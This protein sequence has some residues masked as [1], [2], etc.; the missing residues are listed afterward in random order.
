MSSSTFTYTSVYTDSEPWRFQW[1]SDD[2]LEAPDATPQSP[3]QAPPSPDY[4]SGLEHP[5]SPDYVLGLEEPEQAPL[6]PNYVPEPEYPEYLVP[7]DAEAPIEDH[8]LPYDAS[9]I[10]LSSGYVADSGLEEDP[11]E[12]LTDYPADGG[13]DDDDDDD[14]DGDKEEHKDSDDDDEEEEEERPAPADSS[15]VPVDDPVPSAEDTEAFKTDESA[16]T[17]SSPRSRRARISVRPQT[18]MSAAIEALIAAVA[19]ALPSSPPPSPLLLHSPRFPHHHYLAASPPTHHPSEIPSPP[20][21]LPS[22]SHRDDLPEADMPLRKRARFTAPIGRFEVGESS[23]FAPA[24]QPGLDVATAD[25]TPGRPMSRERVTDLSTTLAQDTHEIYVRLDDALDDRALLRSR[26]NTLFR[27]RRYH[28]H[29]A[30][31][32]ESEAR[33]ARQAWSQAMDCNRAVHAKLLSYRAQA[34]T[35]ETHIQTQDARIGLLET[36]VMTLVAQTSSL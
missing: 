15:V 20:L 28:L 16:P 26:V 9:P 19:A 33:C 29:I 32:V 24:R 1:V 31:L 11:E 27:D 17:P 10:A 34:Q 30:V 7:S 3:G 18:S 25:A 23:A 21:L 4:V 36:L 22:T 2:E 12:D 5:P 13:D 6:S 35:H 8:P 14:D